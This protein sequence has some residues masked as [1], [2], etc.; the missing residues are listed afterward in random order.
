[1]S[2]IGDCI[3]FLNEG[4]FSMKVGSGNE[5]GLWVNKITSC[6]GNKRHLCGAKGIYFIVAL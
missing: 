6:L 1:V 5:E 3:P 2:G 4:Y